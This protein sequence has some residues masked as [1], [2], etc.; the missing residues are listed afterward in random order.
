MI[1]TSS[2]TETPATPVVELVETPE[3]RHYRIIPP[4]STMYSVDAKKQTP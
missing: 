4:G 3:T 1:S 2:I